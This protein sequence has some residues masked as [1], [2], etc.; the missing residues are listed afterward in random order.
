MKQWS[1][2]HRECAA[3]QGT[4]DTTDVILKRDAWVADSLEEVERISWPHMRRDH[5]FYFGNV[6]RFVRSLE[7]TLATYRARA[8]YPLMCTVLDD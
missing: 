3:D 6:P 2:L 7:P 4:I 5:W 8:T 1:D